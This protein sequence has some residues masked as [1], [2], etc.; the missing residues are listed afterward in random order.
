LQLGYHSNIY[1]S[2]YFIDYGSGNIF[3]F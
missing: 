3:I 2:R 1:Y